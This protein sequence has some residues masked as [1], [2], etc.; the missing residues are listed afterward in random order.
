MEA[1]DDMPLEIRVGDD[2][3]PVE[4]LPYE[5]GSFEQNAYGSLDFYLASTNMSVTGDI[6][7]YRLSFVPD[8]G[9][10]CESLAGVRVVKILV[11]AD[12][13]WPSNKVRHVFGPGERFK[14]SF[15]GT[16]YPDVHIVAECDESEKLL[17]VTNLD[18]MFQT[19]CQIVVP[20]GIRGEYIRAMT[21]S[22]SYT[23]S[24]P[25]TWGVDSSVCT[26]LIQKINQE[27]SVDR[28]GNTTIKKLDLQYT[29]NAFNEE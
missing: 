29:R 8:E 5:I 27:I 15:P 13:D 10:R 1:S 3:T 19:E 16:D 11:E 7:E 6:G 24:I 22:G 2:R 21:P 23:L 4:T 26:Q 17:C 12:A 20:D 9:E 25:W 28:Y 18:L 14:I